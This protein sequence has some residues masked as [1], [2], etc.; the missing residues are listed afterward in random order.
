[1]ISGENE[2]LS[3]YCLKGI[4]KSICKQYALKV[5]GRLARGFTHWYLHK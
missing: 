1:M 2:K 3:R 5:P 4:E